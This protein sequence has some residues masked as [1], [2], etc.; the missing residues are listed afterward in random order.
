[1]LMNVQA[2]MTRNVK[3]VG[4]NATLTDAARVMAENNVGAVP[5]VDGEKRVLGIITDRDICLA[6]ANA[7]RLPSQVS[8]E[9]VMSRRVFSCRGDDDIEDA[10]ETMQSRKVRRLPVIGEDGKLEGILSLDDV[11]VSAGEVAGKK[12]PELGYGKTI[13]TLKAI[14]SRAV[15]SKPLAVSS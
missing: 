1:M 10:L 4:A 14:Y 13:A 12:V 15:H 11:V 2:V 8:V 6:V 7:A 3:F 5:V 9:K